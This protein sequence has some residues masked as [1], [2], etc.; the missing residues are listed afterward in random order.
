MPDTDPATIPPD[1]P[2]VIV[3]GEDGDCY[4]VAGTIEA[5][6]A[7]AALAEWWKR[8][9]GYDD[10]EA[11]NAMS[12]LSLTARTDWW[13]QDLPEPRSSELEVD[14]VLRRLDQPDDTYWGLTSHTD[15]PTFA[16]VLF[17]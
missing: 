11:A 12:S 2:T 7:R 16:G 15:Q 4:I 5:T 9:A 13:W 8:E 1:T 10:D 14:Q 6:R 3:L 17:E